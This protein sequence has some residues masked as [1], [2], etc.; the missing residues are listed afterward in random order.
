MH[1]SRFFYPN[2]EKPIPT[3]WDVDRRSV[4]EPMS[5][6]F[7]AGLPIMNQLSAEIEW[8]VTGMDFMEDYLG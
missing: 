8:N 5:R 4:L 6:D 2:M 3:V 1:L 7:P